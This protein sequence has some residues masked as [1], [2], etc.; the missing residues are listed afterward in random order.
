MKGDVDPTVRYRR[1][2]EIECEEEKVPIAPYNSGKKF[3][4]QNNL[5]L[6]HGN[7]AIIQ[8]IF[9]STC[10]ICEPIIFYH[11]YSLEWLEGDKKFRGQVHILL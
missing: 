11:N 5:I 10:N 4:P 2:L 8:F 9:K 1:F 3:S 7:Y 6:I